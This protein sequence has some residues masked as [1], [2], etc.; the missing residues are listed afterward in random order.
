MPPGP[1]LGSAA[2]AQSLPV[3]PMDPVT[4]AR[5]RDKPEFSNLT[6]GK[7]RPVGV[8]APWLCSTSCDCAAPHY[9]SS[10][11]A[12]T[13]F[14][15]FLRGKLLASA[16]LGACVC[17]VLTTHT[18]VQE[19]FAPLKWGES[20]AAALQT[21]TV[22]Q[23]TS[24]HSHNHG[25]FPCINLRSAPE[26]LLDLTHKAPSP[27][28]SPQLSPRCPALPKQPERTQSQTINI[29]LDSINEEAINYFSDPNGSY[30]CSLQGELDKMTFRSPFQPKP[31]Y[32]TLWNAL[33]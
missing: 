18:F 30:P 23:Q 5:L 9:E 33:Q 29:Y 31:F 2:R 24:L 14:S 13:G 28:C 25:D 16:A 12:D 7:A 32:T 19:C 1:T 3:P 22:P 27:R 10:G 8:A 15:R 11:G 17:W 21:H 4:P 20:R 26:P 6:A